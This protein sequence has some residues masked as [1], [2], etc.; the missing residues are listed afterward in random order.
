MT[1]LDDML[2]RYGECCTKV[3]AAR[4]LGRSVTTIRSMLDDGRLNTCCGGSMVDMRSI[5]AYIEA[6][7]AADAKARIEK[8]KLKHNSEWAV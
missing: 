5:A 2:N 7:A 1:R 3:A 6:P 8:F 4:I